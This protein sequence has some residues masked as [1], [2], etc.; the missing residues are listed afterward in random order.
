M[1]LSNKR[2]N[3]FFLSKEKIENERWD[4]KVETK[5]F[6]PEG[7]NPEQ[8]KITKEDLITSLQTGKILEAKVNRCDLRM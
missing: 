4:K 8:V 2:R 7:W 6:F 5:D 1:A 3:Q